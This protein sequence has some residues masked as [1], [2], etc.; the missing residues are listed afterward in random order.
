MIFDIF[1]HFFQAQTMTIVLPSSN[2]GENMDQALSD[3]HTVLTAAIKGNHA[4]T[5]AKLLADG[6]SPTIASSTRELPLPMAIRYRCDPRIVEILL[7]FGASPNLDTKRHKCNCRVVCKA[8]IKRVFS[9]NSKHKRQYRLSSGTDEDMSPLRMAIQHDDSKLRYQ[10]VDLLLKHGADVNRTDRYGNTALLV[11]ASRGD[12]VL[13]QKLLE[14]GANMDANPK[15]SPAEMAITYGH[16][17]AASFIVEHII[18]HG[19]RPPTACIRAAVF[20]CCEKCLQ[21]CLDVGLDLNCRIDDAF[22]IEHAFFNIDVPYW[23]QT[24]RDTPLVKRLDPSRLKIAEALITNGAFIDPI[25]PNLYT[26]ELT[27]C[28]SEVPYMLLLCDQSYQRSNQEECQSR[29]CKLVMHGLVE[30]VRLFCLVAYTPKHDDFIYITEKWVINLD[31]IPNLATDSSY[32]IP[33]CGLYR[34]KVDVAGSEIYHTLSIIDHLSK[35]PRSLQNSAALVI[36]E[37]LGDHVFHKVE[38]LALPNRLKG[39]ITMEN[40]YKR[41]DRICIHPNEH[42]APCFV[43]T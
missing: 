18:N 33:Y 7:Q 42:Q 32:H 40:E 26:H 29:F 30:S 8:C 9:G 35:N 36:R 38:K 31:E 3:G 15:M 39:E 17:E 14:S 37:A 12:Q 34:L 43:C 10:L 11:A 22:P 28:N 23:S 6:A 2:S 27:W 1:I 41:T 24:H 20:K 21:L 19:G 13:I 4:E 5:V 16:C 25:W